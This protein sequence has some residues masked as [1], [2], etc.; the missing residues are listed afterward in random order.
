MLEDLLEEIEGLRIRVIYDS[1]Q[2]LVGLLF[3]EILPFFIEKKKR[4]NFVVHSEHALR[5]IA[6]ISRQYD[7]KLFKDIR[8]FKIGENTNIPFG[9]LEEFINMKDRALFRKLIKV[10]RSFKEGVDIVFLFGFYT[11]PF[12][13]KNS[14]TKILEI[15][16]VM[17][18]RL[19]VIMPQ[20]VNIFDREMNA[21]IGKIF[22]VDFVI[23][24]AEEE[25]LEEAY[26]VHIE[27]SILPKL[28][29]FAKM[30]I[31][32]GKPKWFKSL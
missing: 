7:R 2:V 14:L 20:P 8:I 26:T 9:R 15:F 11:I 23:K 10:F 18:S 17:P 16:E 19:T 21:I 30:K 31:S 4:V 25:Y 12:F 28:K 3:G 13:H 1:R 29:F 32:N 24:R 5:K 6:I 22:D 27:Q